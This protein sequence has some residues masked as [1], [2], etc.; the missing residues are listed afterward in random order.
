[1]TTEFK[2]NIDYALQYEYKFV[3]IFFH[4]VPLV[5]GINL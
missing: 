4:F 1:M 2:G 3:Q 5:Q